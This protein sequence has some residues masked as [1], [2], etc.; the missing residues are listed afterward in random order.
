MNNITLSTFIGILLCCVCYWISK[1]SS[2]G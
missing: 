2:F 1:K